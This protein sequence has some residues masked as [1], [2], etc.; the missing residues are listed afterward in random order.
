MIRK[1]RYYLFIIA[2]TIV[3]AALF[4]IIHDHITYLISPEYF[5]KFKFQQ[6]GFY[7]S[8]DPF[9][10]T[11]PL[12]VTLVGII[13][14][15]WMGLPIGIALAWGSRN[16]DRKMKVYLSSVLLIFLLIIVLESFAFLVT[17]V[18]SFRPSQ[19]LIN[20]GVI[21][22]DSFIT[23][24]AMHTTAYAAGLIGTII[25]VWRLRRKVNS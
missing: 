21:D 2:I 11:I 25:A 8:Q 19:W 16:A 13:A 24:G 6:F 23:V 5:T 7:L 22:Y 14:T 4:G 20:L 10:N 12:A 15:W 17:K 18:I 9:V 3:I 1:F